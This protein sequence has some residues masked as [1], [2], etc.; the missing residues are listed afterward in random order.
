M[1]G[2][3]PRGGSAAP[4]KP[5]DAKGTLKFLWTYI[6]RHKISLIIA[7]IMTV[8]NVVASLYATSLMQPVVDKYLHP[9]AGSLITVDERLAGLMSGVISIAIFFLIECVSSYIQSLLLV[10]FSQRTVNG[11]REDLF[12]YMQSL[13][14]KFYDTNTRGELM[15]RFTNDCDTL[16]EALQNSITTVFS[17][18]I[19][20]IGIVAMMLVRSI[21]LTLINLT[22][23]P[24]M[25][26][27][28]GKIMKKSHTY[29]SKRQEYLGDINGYIEEM[30]GGQKVI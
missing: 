2:P 17:S 22:I 5:K 27:T 19:S 23:I 25:M 16:N 29:F 11:V 7:I 12:N 1:K 30:I 18:A 14:V 4:Q 6:K 20:L 15:S 3:G 9:A 21:P 13:P 28:V 10:R 24:L 26:F 8:V